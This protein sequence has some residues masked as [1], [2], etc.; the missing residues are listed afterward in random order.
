MN[1]KEKSFQ[2]NLAYYQIG[3]SVVATVCAVIMTWGVAE[4]FF[5]LSLDVDSA[6]SNEMLDS[7]KILFFA[8][9]IGIVVF[10]IFFM[11]LMGG[12]RERKQKLTDFR[13]LFDEMYDGKDIEFADKGY[14]TFSV[15]KLRQKGKP[16]QYDYLV[17]K[18]VEENKMILVTEDGE[19]YGGCIEN[20]I[21]CI[22]LGQNPSLEEIEKALEN[23]KKSNDSEK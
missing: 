18:Y 10:T 15:K 8:G 23:L 12:W 7:G 13:I 2:L 5:A 14:D 21:K 16:L 22:K 17:L 3:A 19:N 6:R 20:G 1:Q 9:G 4:I 11:M